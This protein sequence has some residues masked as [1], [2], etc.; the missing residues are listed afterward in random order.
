MIAR[1]G[2][3]IGGGACALLS[4]GLIASAAVAAVLPVPPSGRLGFDI[5]RKGTR[6]G[7]HTLAFTTQANRLTVQSEVS[8]IYKLL[9]ITLY[10]YKHHCI[11]IWDG[12]QV[13]AIDSRTD[14]NGTPF[15]LSARRETGGLVVNATGTPRYT[16]PANALPASHWNQRE[17]DGP[18]IN[19]QNGKL[20][21]PH[22]TPGSE[23]TI[24]AAGGRSLT[25]RRFDLSG[26][27]QMAMWYDRLGWAGLSFDRGGSAIRYERQA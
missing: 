22:V 2:V 10:H 14:D 16:A 26:E 24:P 27:V 5:M 1:R 17:L 18:W 7:S 6:L 25:A 12:G 21:R 23:E 3:L 11:E 13:V 20:L 15:Q 19:T 9:G 8:L 4:G